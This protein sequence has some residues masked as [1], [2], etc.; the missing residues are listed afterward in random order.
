MDQHAATRALIVEDESETL[1]IIEAAC[2][3]LGLDVDTA[4]TGNRGLELALS[5]SYDI[6]LL[7]VQLPSISGFEICAEIR[8][9]TFEPLIIFVTGESREEDR[10]RGLQLGADDYVVKPFSTKELIARLRSLIKRRE[11]D[12]SKATVGT[13]QSE[14]LS[15]KEL[16]VDLRTHTITLRGEEAH[17]TEIEFNLV[18]YFLNNLGR[19]ISREEL[20]DKVWGYTS[21]QFTNTVNSHV[22]RLRN[23]LEIDPENPEY[24]HSVR[25][26]G[27]RFGDS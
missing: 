3:G 12:R 18:C 6:I 26:F 21:S 15:Y 16:R 19:A 23:K 17:F 13:T 24:L 14:I 8:A 7:D 27:Y 20:M 5:N 9:Q 10:V 4:A 22:S 1:R 11:H 25:G 2:I